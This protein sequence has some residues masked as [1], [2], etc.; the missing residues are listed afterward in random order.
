MSSNPVG[1]G[2]LGDADKE[3]FCTLGAH[4]ILG[5]MDNKRR[6]LINY[7]FLSGLRNNQVDCKVVGNQET[8]VKD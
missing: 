3:G 5:D 4:S 6:S 8:S 1:S 7:R 2:D